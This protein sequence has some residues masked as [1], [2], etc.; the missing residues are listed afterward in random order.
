MRCDEYNL[1]KKTRVIVQGITG[2]EGA[3]H[4]RQMMEYGTR[5]VAGVTPGKGG[6]IFKG[7]RFLIL[8]VMLLQETG[9]DASAIFVPP[10]FA[11]DAIMEAVD[12]GIRTVVCLTEGIPT[13]DMIGCETVYE[14]E[15]DNTDRPQYAGHHFT[16]AVQDRGNGRIYPYAG[17]GRNYVKKR[18]AY[19]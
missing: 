14:R 2:R 6:T 11:A 5:I 9:A 10:A 13:L 8:S 4:T 7:C 15:E 1:D 17:A 3:F 12:S 16:G 18:D 19:L